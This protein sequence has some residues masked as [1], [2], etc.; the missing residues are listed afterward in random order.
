MARSCWKGRNCEPDLQLKSKMKRE[1][2]LPETGSFS[3]QLGLIQSGPH[4]M[5]PAA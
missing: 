4:V 5:F 3:L 1:I 2:K